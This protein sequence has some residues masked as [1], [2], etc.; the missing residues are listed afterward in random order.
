MLMNGRCA[1]PRSLRR[2]ELGCHDVDTILRRD[3]PLWRIGGRNL[4]GAMMNRFGREAMAIWADRAPDSLAEIPDQ[5]VFFTALGNEAEG[6]WI[7]L[8][9]ELAGPDLPGEEFLA[10]V[11]RLN[12]ARMRAAEI[13]RSEMLMPP[14]SMSVAPLEEAPDDDPDGVD[15]VM[16]SWQT[17]EDALQEAREEDRRSSQ[18]TELF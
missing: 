12:N 5:E 15:P 16:R 8:S 17:R 10:K 14:S 9:R 2:G 6:A 18:S 3:N 7:D 13:I 11:G 1:H 4:R